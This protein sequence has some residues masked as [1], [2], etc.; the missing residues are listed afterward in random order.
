MPRNEGTATGLE[1]TDANNTY[2]SDPQESLLGRS[3]ARESEMQ[4]QCY[5][6]NHTPDCVSQAVSSDGSVDHEEA[7]DD[8][9]T[10][11]KYRN[12]SSGI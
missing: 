8:Q 12:L 9:A 7:V 4:T 2:C 1:G 6:S 11:A 10:F 3:G 5:H